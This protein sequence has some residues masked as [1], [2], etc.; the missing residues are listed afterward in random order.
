MKWLAVCVLAVVG[1]IELVLRF[2]FSLLLVLS[3]LGI[4][5]LAMS[6]DDILKPQCFE[7]IGQ[8]VTDDI[9]SSRT[10]ARELER[11]RSQNAALYHTNNELKEIIAWDKQK[12]LAPNG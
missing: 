10:S 7:W 1:V 4:M 12:E 5:V 8:I 11:L 2:L 3:L 6:G 9:T